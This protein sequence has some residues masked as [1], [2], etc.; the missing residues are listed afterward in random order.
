M[1]AAF[2]VDD[3]GWKDTVTQQ[4]RVAVHQALAGLQ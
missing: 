4:A 3:D 2:H 1:R